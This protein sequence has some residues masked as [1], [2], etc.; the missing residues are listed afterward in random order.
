MNEFFNIIDKMVDTVLVGGLTI[1]Y[2]GL[3]LSQAIAIVFVKYLPYYISFCLL[4]AVLYYTIK[5]RKK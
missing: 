2:G 4:V 5:R 1:G 3:P